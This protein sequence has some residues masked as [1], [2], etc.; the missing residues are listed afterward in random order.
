MGCEEKHGPTRHL[1]RDRPFFKFN[2]QC[3]HTCFPPFRSNG[4]G[5]HFI[6]CELA[7]RYY[8]G[9]L[10]SAVSCCRQEFAPFHGSDSR[11]T[12]TL[13]YSKIYFHTLDTRYAPKSIT[14]LELG[15]NRPLVFMIHTTFDLHVIVCWRLGSEV[16]SSWRPRGHWVVLA[17]NFRLDSS[18]CSSL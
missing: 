8:W 5:L 11:Q 13:R 14:A 17:M 9:R 6:F 18:L 3:L 15:W 1:A 4:T 10:G 12:H 7:P 2:E 16:D